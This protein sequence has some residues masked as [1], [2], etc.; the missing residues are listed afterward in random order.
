MTAITRVFPRRTKATPTDELAFV[1]PPPL[2]LPEADEVHISVAF[3]WDKPAAEHLAKCWGQY[4]PVKIGGPAY[5]DAGAAFTPGLYLKP[6][7]TFTS[8]GC[9]NKCG[10]CLAW[11]REGPLRLLPI[12]PGYIV[13]DNNLLACPRPHIEAVLDMLSNQRRQAEFAGGLEAAH[14][15]PWFVKAVTDIGFKRAY[16]AYDRP[17]ERKPVAEALR[18]FTEAMR[19]KIKYTH[20]KLSV[21]VLVGFAGDTLDQAAERCQFVKD[22]SGTPFPMYFEPA[23]PRQQKPREWQEFCGR[24]LHATGWAKQTN[25][26]TANHGLFG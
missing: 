8:R 2:H 13:L 11:R 3:T 7:Y 18:Q 12:T 6:G 16:F 4:Y 23:G 17:A 5:D 15:E 22:H 9:P 26:Q 21:Y 24:V 19:G 10:F 25:P 1:G 14:V 20:S